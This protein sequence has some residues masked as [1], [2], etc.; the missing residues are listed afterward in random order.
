MGALPR[1]GQLTVDVLLGPGSHPP[2]AVTVGAAY[3]TSD[4]ERETEPEEVTTTG[5]LRPTPGGRMQLRVFSEVT[6]TLVHGWALTV[7]VTAAHKTE[8][9]EAT[10][11]RASVI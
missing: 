6:C 1:R 8:N 4:T 2:T 7:T 10:H 11:K 3:D 5:R 9:R